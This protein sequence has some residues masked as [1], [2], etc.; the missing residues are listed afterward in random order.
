MVTLKVVV[1]ERSFYP[2]VAVVCREQIKPEDRLTEVPTILVEVLSESTEAF[3]KGK[4]WETYQEI[5]SLQ[6]YVLIAQGELSAECYERIG[7]AWRYAHFTRR[8]D[9]LVIECMKVHVPL[10]TIY[11]GVEVPEA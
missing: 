9:S 8:E 1:D 6:A 5:E 7:N 11:E 3:D 4:K 2:D 10:A